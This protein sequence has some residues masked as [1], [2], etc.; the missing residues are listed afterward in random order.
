MDRIE[1]LDYD[2]KI[3]QNPNLYTFTSDSVLLAKFVKAKAG[4]TVVDL[5][6]GSGVI[7]IYLTSSTKAKKIIGVELQTDLAEMARR[8]VSLNKLEDKVEILN[9]NMK[10][11]NIQADVIVSNPP[12]KKAGAILNDNISRAIARHEIEINLEDLIKVVKKNLK[13]GG[14]FYIS[15]DA[16]RT[17]ELIFELKKNGLEPKSLFYTYSQNGKEASLVFIKAVHGGKPSIK[18]LKPIITNNESGKYIENLKIEGE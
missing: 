6:T 17:A 16:N 13:F 14:K 18:V 1:Y 15:Y 7:A 4:E 8:S 12:Y 5:G 2:L 9:M 3:Y 10:E 11:L